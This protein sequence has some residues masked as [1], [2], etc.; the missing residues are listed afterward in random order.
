TIPG[1]VRPPTFSVSRRQDRRERSDG[2]LR[3]A[4]RRA[5]R[6]TMH[7]GANIPATLARGRGLARVRALL[8]I[9]VLAAMAALGALVLWQR[10]VHDLDRTTRR[11]LER[12]GSGRSADETRR[13][14]A[15][16]E[17]ESGATLRARREDWI[18]HV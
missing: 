8:A 5:E 11:G 16:W 9:L 7:G 12:L 1:K 15:Q 10:K 4:A 17:R 13:G 2:S 6:A 18:S 14:L 3:A